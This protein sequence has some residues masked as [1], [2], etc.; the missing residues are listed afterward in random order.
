ML[1]KIVLGESRL[2]ENFFYQTSLYVLPMLRD[3]SGSVGDG[4]PENEVTSCLTVKNETCLFQSFY[5]FSRME[6]WQPRHHASDILN[7]RSKLLSFFRETFS[8]GIGS[9]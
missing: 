5:D 9:P 6:G 2:L 4:M 3:A 8:V 1:P 7:G